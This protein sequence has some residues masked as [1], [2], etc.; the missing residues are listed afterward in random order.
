MPQIN[1]II[2][3]LATKGDPNIFVSKP[4]SEVELK[5]LYK[6][7]DDLEKKLCDVQISMKPYRK[8]NLMEFENSKKKE[9]NNTIMEEVKK[10]LKEEYNEDMDSLELKELKKEMNTMYK[11]LVQKIRPLKKQIQK[12]SSSNKVFI[13]KISGAKMAFEFYPTKQISELYSEVRRTT[14]EYNFDLVFGCELLYDSDTCFTETG[15]KPDTK[16]YM[17]Q[18]MSDY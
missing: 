6:L 18:Q 7:E 5:E 17:V 2:I 13:I 11:N 9:N 8:K 16:I 3:R 12:K 1:N 15:I 14:G 4:L 10:E